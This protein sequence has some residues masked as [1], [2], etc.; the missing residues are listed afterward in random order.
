MLL[1]QQAAL[2]QECGYGHERSETRRTPEGMRG[3]TERWHCTISSLAAM[4]PARPAEVMED[5][6]ERARFQCGRRILGRLGELHLGRCN[7]FTYTI[8]Q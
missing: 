4:S 5:T 8:A 3:F 7:P 2:V 1:D 6:P